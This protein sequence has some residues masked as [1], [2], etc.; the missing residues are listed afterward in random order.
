MIQR[1]IKK[2]KGSAGYT[3]TEMTAV[4][5]T[6][7]VL[8]AVMLPVAISQ[9]QQGRVT[10][11]AGDV[12]AI[13]AALSGILRD[14]QDYPMRN[15]SAQ[16][17][18]VR[19]AKT[20]L[21]ST[22]DAGI[23]LQ[24]AGAAAFGGTDAAT[25]VTGSQDTFTPHFYENGPTAVASDNFYTGLGDV[26]WKGPYLTVK[27][28]DPWGTSYVLYLG[29]VQAAA[30]VTPCTAICTGNVI[31][32]SAGPDRILNTGPTATSPGGDDIMQLLSGG[33]LS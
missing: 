25:T 10:A 16:T 31:V 33:T 26:A 15:G 29:P 18:S 8:T 17:P 14:T 12:A 22:D 2:L 19:F 32:L 4:V 1:L 11:A 23:V 30:G 21:F 3:L 27:K 13:G 20:L 9:V 6:A 7:G 24:P 28:L 5:A